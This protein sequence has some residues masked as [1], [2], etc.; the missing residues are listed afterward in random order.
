MT[1]EPQ[2]P[3]RRWN[4][5]EF[6][7]MSEIGVLSPRGYELLDGVVYDTNGYLRRWSVRDYDRMAEAGLITAEER[8]ELV[9]G[10]VV[11]PLGFKW[12][13]ASIAMRLAHLLWDAVRETRIVSRVTSVVLDDETM[14]CPDLAVLHYRDDFYADQYPGPEDV[15]LVVEITEPLSSHY[16]GTKRGLYANAGMAE[17][18]E[19]EPDRGVVVVCLAPEAGEYRDHREYRHGQSWVSPALGGREVRVEDVLGPPLAEK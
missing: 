2:I 9:E 5:D 3:L 15:P 18:W 17:L 10:C 7:R 14:I 8:A 11:Q 1:T 4:V 13:R 12:R 6:D 16:Y 19:L